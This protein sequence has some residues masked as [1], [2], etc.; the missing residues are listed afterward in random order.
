MEGE[1]DLAPSLL[2]ALPDTCLLT[3]LQCLVDDQCA[4]FNAARAHSRLRQA[5]AVTLRNVTTNVTVQQHAGSVLVYLSKHGQHVDSIDLEGHLKLPAIPWQLPHSLQLSSLHVQ[6]VGLPLELWPGRNAFWGAAGVAGLK[7]LCVKDCEFWD[8]GAE[9][10]GWDPLHTS[11]Q[12]TTSLSE[13]PPVL[14]HLSIID[15]TVMNMGHDG[16]FWIGAD[17]FQYLQKLTFLEINTLGVA[18]L[19]QPDALRMTC[20]HD[21]RLETEGQGGPDILLAGTLA[22]AHNLTRLDLHGCKT[23]VDV[24]AG[25][26]LLRHLDLKYYSCV[27]GARSHDTQCGNVVIAPLL[28]HLKHLQ[29]LTYLVVSHTLLTIEDDSPL[30]TYSTITASSKL[31]H[32]DISGSSL[33]LG[34][35]Q[36]IFPA[37]RQLP[38]MQSLNISRIWQPQHMWHTAPEGSRLVSCC[39]SLQCL[40]MEWLQGSAEWLVPLQGFSG[41]HTLRLATKDAAEAEAM[42]LVCHLRGLKKLSIECPTS[43]LEEL[44]LQMTELKQLTWLRYAGLVDWD[45]QPPLQLFLDGGEWWVNMPLLVSGS[46]LGAGRP[47]SYR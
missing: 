46:I 26:T 10:V 8:M 22:G 39:P 30:T 27:M 1:L 13:L 7:R 3:V 47:I 43:T 32:L 20:L 41:L 37:G 9:Y 2:L 44:L 4:L 24:L 17:A 19:Y 45:I 15:V 33:P 35:W 31:R 28:A 36:H 42:P 40:S 25:K 12:L 16:G 14:E 29:Q 6:L 21:L 23:E 11:D 34:V 18:W 5:S 38:H